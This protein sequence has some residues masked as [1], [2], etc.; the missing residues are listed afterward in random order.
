MGLQNCSSRAPIGVVRKKLALSFL[1]CYIW[2]EVVPKKYIYSSILANLLQEEGPVFA[3]I[4]SHSPPIKP[5]NHAGQYELV[6]GR[7]SRTQHLPT[8]KN[9]QRKEW[10]D[11]QFSSV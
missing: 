5:G 11:V 8:L 9:I 2:K 6:I 10:K 7:K 3:S 4:M 1:L